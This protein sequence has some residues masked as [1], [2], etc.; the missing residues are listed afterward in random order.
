MSHKDSRFAHKSGVLAIAIVLALAGLAPWMAYGQDRAAQSSE[1]VVSGT[2]EVGNRWRW[3]SGN[4]DLYRS[5]VNLGRGPKL[6]SFLMNFQSSETSKP[7]LFDRATFSGGGWGGE[8]AGTLRF[9]GVKSDRYEFQVNYRHFDYFSS[10]PSFANPTDAR[11]GN[12]QSTFDVSRQLFDARLTFWP[13]RAVSPYVGFDY[14]R[15]NGP[16]RTNFV[17]DAN[18][19]SV[20]TNVDNST[21]AVRGG[22][23]LQFSRWSGGFEIGRSTFRDDQSI[24]VRGTNLGNRATLFLGQRLQL[25]ALSQAY[26][27][28]GRDIFS[29]T[30]MMARPWQQL[31]VHG[32]FLYSR[33]T[34]ESIY[35]DQGSGTFVLQNTLETFT[36]EQTFSRAQARNPHPSGSAGAELQLGDRLR[37]VETISTDRFSVNGNGDTNQSFTLSSRT[38]KQTYDELLKADF[39]RQRLNV[40]FDLTSF[41]SIHAGHTYLTAS[42][43][44]PGSDLAAPETRELHRNSADL[45]VMF[46]IRNRLRLNL[47]VE[48]ERGN[49][50]FF[51]TDLRRFQ[52]LRARGR[53]QVMEAL[54]VGAS[55]SVWNNKNDAADTHFDER[56]REESVDV[57][58][59]PQS[60]KWFSVFASYTRG[61]FRSDLPFIVPQNFQTD[62]SIYSDRGHTGSLW[63]NI[64]PLPRLQVQVGGDAFVST[65][66]SEGTTQ[67]R[68]T[69][70]YNPRSRLAL[71]VIRDASFVTEWKWHEYSNRSFARENYRAHLLMTGVEYRW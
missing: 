68:P 11:S 21:A 56:S 46:R 35:V 30:F 63:V 58:Y 2:V 49:A 18:E 4:E 31:T 6:N 40:T 13:T 22:I 16:A 36:G 43:T 25:E 55:A 65:P 7:A 71:N 50:T 53:Y 8:P 14:D 51:R 66:A 34:S 60:G 70:F 57:N 15:T 38:V 12:T 69:R 48:D 67:A 37:I 5:T 45:G 52:K 32:Q 39:T 10:I 24:D 20:A 27:I 64:N 23:G 42:A 1:S 41:S 47:D 9:S 28:S 19:Y 3:L 33:P 44:S 29:R 54:Q 59:A 26:K 17:Q 62:R 61:T